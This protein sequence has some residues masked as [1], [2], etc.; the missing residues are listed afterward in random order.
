MLRYCFPAWGNSISIEHL[1][2][3]WTYRIREGV[4]WLLKASLPRNLV[5]K[6]KRVV[7]TN[8]DHK[9][10]RDRYTKLS[11][12]YHWTSASTAIHA[13]LNTEAARARNKSS[14]LILVLEPVSSVWRVVA[15]V[16]S[17]CFYCASYFNANINGGGCKC[18]L[19][20]SSQANCFWE[21]IINP[22]HHDWWWQGQ[23]FCEWLV[24]QFPNWLHF[25]NTGHLK[26]ETVVNV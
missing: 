17:V 5:L 19:I 13:L 3:T 24:A 7:R 18:E 8:T 9:M 16:P 26:C 21:V 10:G 12:F 6:P 20:R 1:E 11:P 25:A 23:A 22:E 15:L 4:G 2:K 14:N